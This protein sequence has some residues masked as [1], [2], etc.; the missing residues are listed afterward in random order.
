MS[1]L[2]PKL[3]PDKYF[4]NQCR[5]CAKALSLNSS[6]QGTKHNI[7]KMTSCCNVFSCFHIK[8]IRKFALAMDA[9]Y[10]FDVLTYE[11]DNN[12]LLY[13]FL[14]EKI[15]F[16]AIRSTQSKWALKQLLL[17]CVV[18]AT[19]GVVVTINTRLILSKRY[20]FIEDAKDDATIDKDIL[21]PLR[22]PITTLCDKKGHWR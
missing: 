14:C 17:M 19:N 4:L 20:V 2:R 1:K 21:P 12:L 5:V 6:R 8:C 22:S 9:S 11:S 15:A 10:K 18:N 13:C 7:F 16:I 3:P